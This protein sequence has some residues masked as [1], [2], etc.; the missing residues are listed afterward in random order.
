MISLTVRN[1]ERPR[2]VKAWAPRV[3]TGCLT[4][5]PLVLDARQSDGRSLDVLVRRGKPAL[6]MEAEPPDWEF[7]EGIRYF[8]EIVNPVRVSNLA[9][10]ERPQLSVERTFKPNFMTK[11]MNEYL[12][13]LAKS[14][15]RFI[16]YG[17]DP[18]V[19]LLSAKRHRYMLELLDVTNRLI[20]GERP[21]T[22]TF[23]A[24]KLIYVLM[25]NSEYVRGDLWT[26]HFKGFLAYVRHLGGVAKVLS[27]PDDPIPEL[28]MM[29]G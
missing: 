12:T 26:T 8:Y 28:H 27:R 16:G 7:L 1:A 25:V 19:A 29:L 3:R 4:C 9:D 23:N 17:D 21:S 22:P 10:I 18:S 11:V 20:S 24:F 5:R 2:A 13:N 6:P 15:A 14:Q